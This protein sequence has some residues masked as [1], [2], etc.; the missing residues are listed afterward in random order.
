MNTTEQ[1]PE[2]TLEEDFAK[3]EQMIGQLEKKD[4]PLEESFRI[5]KE[6]MELLKQCSDRIDT[7]EKKMILMNED[8]EIDEF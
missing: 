8:C 6:G 1:K 2:S 4:I 3:L 7:V 5:Y